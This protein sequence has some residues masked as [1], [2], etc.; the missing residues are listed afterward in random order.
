[1]GSG[2]CLRRLTLVPQ[3]P[4][5]LLVGGRAQ[6]VLEPLLLERLPRPGHV[7]PPGVVARVLDPR[8]VDHGEDGGHHDDARPRLV[9][10]D[11]VVGGGLGPLA[12]AAESE[13]R[14]NTSYIKM[15]DN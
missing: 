14:R 12:V 11:G 13:G 8:E 1:M 3:V 6:Q 10:E 2:K 9:R 4:D 5:L 15:I 7:R